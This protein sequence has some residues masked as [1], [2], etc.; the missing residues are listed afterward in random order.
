MPE[1]I[2]TYTADEQHPWEYTW[3]E[4]DGMHAKEAMMVAGLTV[5]NP[6]YRTEDKVLSGKI[7][8]AHV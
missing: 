2:T 8:R 7:G 5:N 6:V 3:I 1:Q 4:F